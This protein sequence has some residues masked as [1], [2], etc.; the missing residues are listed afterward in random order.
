[1]K[2]AV[3]GCGTWGTAFARLMANEGNQVLLVCR[4]AEQADAINSF[5]RNPRYLFDIALPDELVA[6]DSAGADLSDA[7]VVAIA[8]PSRAF[9]AVTAGIGGRMGPH[10]VLLSMTKGL[11]PLSGKRLSEIASAQLDGRRLAVLSGPNHAEEVA[12]DFPMAAVV[13]AADIDL[14]RELQAAISS[15]LLRVYASSDVVGVELCGATKNVIGLTA[16]ISDGLGF[17]DNAKAAII[18]RGMAEMYRLG[19]A[20]GADPRTYSGM[21]GM[22]DLVATCTS[23]HSRNRRAGELLAQGVPAGWI[24]SEIGQVAE[25]LTTAPVLREV[26]RGRG[27]ELPITN[28]VCEIAFEGKDPLAVLTE[29]MARADPV[30]E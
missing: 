24:E 20:F 13:A 12:H 14:A 18:T 2:I 7:G 22:G 3:I 25:G 16:G 28:A 4:G 26:A 23:R 19:T 15:R 27:L 5:H 17:G 9:S 21:A 30:E 6:A 8:V 10:A 29:L 1:V 11:D